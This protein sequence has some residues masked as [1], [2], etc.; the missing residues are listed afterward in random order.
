MEF[1]PT[2]RMVFFLVTAIATFLFSMDQRTI[3]EKA[4]IEHQVY[5]T[6]LLHTELVQKMENLRTISTARL[7]N[8]QSQTDSL[9][10]ILNGCEEKAL[11]P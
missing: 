1:N 9:Q 8:Q 11:N 6:E 3:Y 10:S 4:L 5:E 2:I 7:L